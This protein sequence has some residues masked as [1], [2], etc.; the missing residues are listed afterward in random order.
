MKKVFGG[1]ILA[2]SIMLS[3]I[4]CS[5][6]SED[7]SKFKKISLEQFEAFIDS[8][9]DVESPYNTAETKY[10]SDYEYE[11]DEE[12]KYIRLGDKWITIYGSYSYSRSTYFLEHDACYMYEVMKDE[13]PHMVSYSIYKNR[14]QYKL[15]VDMYDAVG[16][17]LINKYGNLE[18]L[19][20]TFL[21]EYLKE[22]NH[23]C[24]EA[25]YL[26]EDNRGIS[27][28]SLAIKDMYI[29]YNEDNDAYSF[30]GF[31]QRIQPRMIRVPDVYD[32]GVNGQKY[33]TYVDLH[34]V[35]YSP[36]VLRVNIPQHVNEIGTLH[37][38]SEGLGI[39]SFSS[40]EVDN[41]NLTYSSFDECLYSKDYSKF[42]MCP[43]GRS[44]AVDIHYQAKTIEIDAF[45]N[46]QKIKNIGSWGFVETIRVGAF[47]N[48]SFENITLPNTIT[49][50]EN[51][52]FTNCKTLKTIT[53]N[54]ELD[55]VRPSIIANCESL[56]EVT[57]GHGA[58]HI[59]TSIIGQ[60]TNLKKI[61]FNGTVEE[62]DK[63]HIYGNGWRASDIGSVN[64]ITCTDGEVNIV[65]E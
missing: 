53:L 46:C 37:G 23:F 27:C 16:E 2:A 24:F 3:T 51:I 34:A 57:I 59:Y 21:D 50:L 7:G 1:L 48:S 26:I 5:N 13:F 60:C 62:W 38:W 43:V 45:R 54:D 63:V 9:K 58:K 41:D 36:S 25:K 8:I 32:D 44:D 20:M 18:Y 31:N 4:G 55:Y 42:L 33:L 56:E 29:K 49:T 22:Q 64:K 65:V 12:T 61:K 30:L 40:I 19:N 47:A 14:S 11:Q 28:D 6:S 17:C 35:Y 52:V 39:V 15:V 10:E